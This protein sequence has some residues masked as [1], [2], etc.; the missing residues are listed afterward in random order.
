MLK[1]RSNELTHGLSFVRFW[2]R[3]G[4]VPKREKRP[5]ETVVAQSLPERDKPMVFSVHY[6]RCL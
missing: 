2:G 6:R 1:Q 5:S 4:E 3:K